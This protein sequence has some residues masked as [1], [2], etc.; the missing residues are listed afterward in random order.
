L[1]HS[2]KNKIA[3]RAASFFAANAAGRKRGVVMD[4]GLARFTR[5]PE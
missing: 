4:S 5:A 3:T 1:G 2:R